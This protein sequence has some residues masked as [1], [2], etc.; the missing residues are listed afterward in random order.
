MQGEAAQMLDAPAFAEALLPCEVPDDPVLRSFLVS[1]QVRVDSGAGLLDHPRFAKAPFPDARQLPGLAARRLDAAL[2]VSCAGEL[3]RGRYQQEHARRA[4][5]AGGRWCVSSPVFCAKPAGCKSKRRRMLSSSARVTG[6]HRGAMCPSCAVIFEWTVSAEAE[7]RRE[8][9]VAR[10]VLDETK[11]LLA[12]QYLTETPPGRLSNAFDL[13][14]KCACR[15]RQCRTVQDSTLR[16]QACCM[17]HTAS[18][19]QTTRAHPSWKH[20]PLPRS[21]FCFRSQRVTTKGGG[22]GCGCRP[23]ARPR[24]RVGSGCCRHRGGSRSQQVSYPQAA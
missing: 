4:T 9:L 6:W 10:T 24:G 17:L 15:C 22:S 21:A 11:Q 23:G 2:Y 18:P 5:R 20:I 19:D 1:I 14:E 13:F 16:G 3:L 8:W 12:E 7:K